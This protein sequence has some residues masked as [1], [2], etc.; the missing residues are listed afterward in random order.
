MH[1]VACQSTIDPGDSWCPKCGA[2]ARRAD[3]ESERRFV[4][5]LRA[6]VIDS[7]GLVAELEPEEAVSRLEPA[8]AAMRAAVRQFGGIVSK[9][10]GD[11]LAAV[12]GA[13]IADDNHAPLACHA[14][15]ELV[16]RVGS[17]GDPGLQVRVGLHS[18]HVVAYMVASEFSKV[19]EIGGAAQHLAARLETA[20][21]ANQIYVSE[22]CQE[23]ADGHV[24]FEF[25]GGKALRGFSQPL[26][27]YRIVGASDLSSWRVRR[28]RSISRFVDRTTERALLGRAAQGVDAGRQ[29]VLL[30]GDAGIGKSR[31]A[32]EFAQELKADGWRL[33]DAE[34]SPNLQGA[35][36]STLKRLLLSILEAA[37]K[38]SDGPADPRTDRPL[39]QQCALDAVLDLPI[40]EPQWNELEPH[41]RG[42]AI[43]DA[44]CAIVESTARRRR[45]V[46]LVEDLHWID[47]ASDTVIAAI[48]SLQVPDLLVL[49]TSRP[50]G[51][52]VW[53]ARCRAEVVAMRPL[54]DDSGL[55][56]LADML[57]PSAAN[58]DLKSRI[59]SHT[60]NVPLFIEEVCRGLR[61]SGTLRGQWGDL[62]LV[63]PIEELGIPTSIQGVIAA[64]LDRVSRQQ[65][66]VLQIA[67][68]LGPRSNVATLR[69]IADLAEDVLQDCLAA[70][71]RAELLV[72]VDSELDDALEFRHEMVRQVTYDSMV[73]KVR[74]GI[75]AR[76]L[77]TLDSDGAHAD[78][79]DTLC[80]HAARAKDWH[81]A[82]GHGRNAGRKCLSRSAFADAA[83][84]FEI[85]MGSLDK[86]P[87]APLRETDAIDLRMEARAA[88]IA[89][90]QVAEWLDLGKEAERRADAID[91]IGRK[92]AAMTVRAGAQN[93]YGAPVEAVAVSEEVVRL[94]EGWRNLGWLNLARYGLGQAYFLAGRYREAV[95][96]LALAHAQL[97]GPDASAPIGTTPRYLLLLCCMMKSFTHAVMG[98][99]DV[100]EQLQQEAAAIAAETNRPYDRVAATYSGGWLKLGRNEPAAAAAILE[101]GFVLAQ[102]HGIRLFVPVLGCHLG[103]AYL[104]QGLFDRARGMLTE[105]REEAKAVG[106]TSAVLRS[107]IYL[108]LATYRLGDA[109]A[110]QNILREA[111]NTARQQGFSG[112]EAEAL[113][114]EAVVTPP[115][116]AKAR[117]AILAALRATIAIAAESGALPLQHKA[118]AMLSEM[119]TRDDELT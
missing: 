114:G 76:I 21:E 107:S 2:A 57:G 86:M 66:S 19:Y 10:L 43:C 96:I 93:F 33:I 103:M 37:A 48:A 31:L 72:K 112:L 7:T 60:A 42:R 28:A 45:T 98:E 82:F 97:A 55:A 39:I 41:A 46:L 83:N 68:A 85:A 15:I 13:P 8:L 101:E 53:I 58:A 91:D 63:R 50:S 27:V 80:Y 94:A 38:D 118:E 51:T 40:S 17:L 75:H 18:G 26:P 5:I 109:Q 117:A 30:L 34:C 102:K 44:S 99:L 14:A 6:D 56:M 47:R 62:A 64:R 74:E 36:F 79:P 81:K 105:A 110:A 84:Y 12:F 73:E 69:K 9:E 23:L 67:A 24:R 78:E 106:Y 115:S 100:A 113:F 89:S 11:G 3:P 61:D 77:E 88:F 95:Q 29:T 65:R 35:P 71:D 104:E 16:R 111:R 92:V 4:T 49:L 20:A 1:C 25:L 87:M 54:D 119:L 32:H 22:A 70:L 52:P 59:I 116:D 90:G 108:A